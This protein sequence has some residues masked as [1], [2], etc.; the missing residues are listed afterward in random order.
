MVGQGTSFDTLLRITVGDDTLRQALLAGIGRTHTYILRRK[1]GS[2]IGQ[3]RYHPG[4]LTA[5]LSYLAPALKDETDKKLWSDLLDGLAVMAGQRGVA[6]IIAEVDQDS[7]EYGLLRVSGFGVYTR[8]DIWG[9]LPAPISKDHQPVL[10]EA[11][12]PDSIGMQSL[13]NALI[14]G[15]VHQI[16]PLPNRAE[17]YIL[18]NKTGFQGMVVVHR[19]GRN[20]LCEVY[21]LQDAY[22]RAGAVVADVLRIV[23]ADARPTYCRLRADTRI[24]GNDLEAVG[25][26]QLVTQALMVRHT[27]ARVKLTEFERLPAIDRAIRMRNTFADGG[28]Q[29]DAA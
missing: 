23:G 12:P 15:L 10:R 24:L 19:G 5:K 16:E 13:Y 9:R 3:L 2:G 17:G 25:F 29:T 22:S 7:E 18:E 1:S 6:N 26:E 11:R 21:L 4:Q 14:P 28:V 27:A 20:T 8:Q